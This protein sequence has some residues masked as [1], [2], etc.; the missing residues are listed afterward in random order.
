MR[1][2][3]THYDKTFFERLDWSPDHGTVDLVTK[4]EAQLGALPGYADAEASV[5]HELRSVLWARRFEKRFPKVFTHAPAA[6]RN[7]PLKRLISRPS[8]EAVLLT[9]GVAPV[10]SNQDL[11]LLARALTGCEPE[12][13]NTALQ[14][15]PGSRGGR[16]QYPD[17]GM[18]RSL[19]AERLS[20]GPRT[21]LLKALTLYY[22]LNVIHPFDDGN[23]RT[24]RAVLMLDLSALFGWRGFP[25]SFLAYQYVSAFYVVQAFNAGY[26]EARLGTFLAR[27][28]PFLSAA[29][30]ENRLMMGP[31]SRD[32]TLENNR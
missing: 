14:S 28:I 26:A 5:G 2:G 18:I 20:R 11:K 21:N 10:V 17:P 6:W 31:R 29:A 3:A 24:A 9:S 13:R 1:V 8:V 15:A 25:F 27:F 16:T 23:G 7:P 12:I 4:L 19:L 22:A 30:Y 32:R